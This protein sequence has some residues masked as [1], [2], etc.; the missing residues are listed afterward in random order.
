M[1][2]SQHV[3]RIREEG[4]YLRLVDF[5]ITQLYAEGNKERKKK[6]LVHPREEIVEAQPA[7][8]RFRVSG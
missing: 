8:Q 1:S 2:T 4:S 5:C 7:V 6:K 3:N